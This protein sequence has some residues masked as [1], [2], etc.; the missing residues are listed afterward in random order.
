MIPIRAQSRQTQ[1]DLRQLRLHLYIAALGLDSG[2]LLRLLLLSQQN[3]SLD[4]GNA[5][6][7]PGLFHLQFGFSL[8]DGLQL[9][10]FIRKLCCLRFHLPHAVPHSLQCLGGCL[11]D[12]CLL[13]RADHGL[14][15]QKL[16]PGLLQ[17]GL[18]RVQL[19]I[20]RFGQSAGQGIH[21]L[22][23]ED[24]IHLPLQKAA[25]GHAGN[26]CDALHLICQG[27][28]HELR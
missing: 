1:V 28:L 19:L 17:L 4:G 20:H 8:Q 5:G 11:C 3:V 13:R 12:G 14:G 23:A 26:P 24:H 2:D 22:L 25:D 7:V 6:V 9:G 21:L 15:V 27:L 10:Q 16:L 18:G